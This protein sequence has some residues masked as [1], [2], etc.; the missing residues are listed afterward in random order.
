MVAGVGDEEVMV[1]S[2]GR[3]AVCADAH[4]NAVAW[5]AVLSE[6]TATRPDLLVFGG[7]LTWGP[8]PA[9]TC[10][11]TEAL[12]IPV[13][14]VRG[15]AERALA[16]ATAAVAAG[17]GAS[18][19]PRERWLVDRHTPEMHA[20]LG[21]CRESAVVRVE[22]LGDVRFCHGSP[23][24]DEELVTDET[25]EARIRALLDGIGER[26]L[27][28]AHTHLQ[29]DREVAG[30]RS[31]NPG[32][33]GMPYGARAG[34]AYWALLGPDVEL[35]QT[36]YDLDEAVE[37]YRSSGDPLAERMVDILVS[38]PTHDE[39]VAHAEKAEFSG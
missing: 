34:T 21:H 28:T 2:T 19:T 32:S 31:V 9:E 11:L 33:V 35:R 14:F 26:I 3:V 8:L 20:L 23:R 10:A 6:I 24:S 13:I 27:V 1:P 30:I 37:R 5:E 36:A 22:G 16:E 38:P 7:D 17:N 15:N 39:V 18:L 12:E 4:G 25:P 29:F